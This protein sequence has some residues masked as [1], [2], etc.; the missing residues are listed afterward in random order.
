[1]DKSKAINKQSL[2]YKSMDYNALRKEGIALLEKHSGKSWT[3]FNVHDPGV[4][5]LEVLCYVITELGYKINFP[6]EDILYS[7]PDK[8]GFTLKEN[9]FFEARDIFPCQPVTIMDFRKLLIDRIEPVN[10]AWVFL[11]KDKKTGGLF[12]IWLLLDEDNN[13]REEDVIKEGHELMAEHR[14]LC[15]DVAKISIL[16]REECRLEANIF[17]ENKIDPEKTA[18]R[19]LFELEK[20]MLNPTLLR[21]SEKQMMKNGYAFENIF[22]GPEMHHGY[23]LENS[24]PD[25]PEEL[26]LLKIMNTILKIDGVYHI[27]DLAVVYKGKRYT[28]HFPLDSFL[29]IFTSKF[30]IAGG[31]ELS[32]YKND[33]LIPFQSEESVLLY[34]QLKSQ[35]KRNYS[36]DTEA[37]A[38][39]GDMVTGRFRTISD[40]LSLQNE[41]PVA[42][43][44]GK[45]GLPP[46]SD[47]KR[48]AQ[49]KQLK[50]FLLHFEQLLANS[51]VQ[52]ANLKKLFSIYPA[53]QT[54]FHQPLTDVPNLMPLIAED[55]SETALSQ[56]EAEVQHYEK[57]SNLVESETTF[58]TRRN[59]FLN[60]LLAR[61]NVTFNEA[62]YYDFGYFPEKNT[63]LRNL[64]S[65]KEYYLQHMVLLS[66]NRGKGVNYLRENPEKTALSFKRQL[67]LLL[68]IQ[69]NEDKKLSTAVKDIA[70]DLMFTIDERDDDPDN[71]I[72]YTFTKEELLE[73]FLKTGIVRENYRIET[74][75]VKS[76]DYRILLDLQKSN[77]TVETGIAETMENAIEDVEQ[78]C[79]QVLQRSIDTE[80]FYVIEHLLLRPRKEDDAEEND[81][82]EDE[83]F[84]NHRMSLIFPSWPA[85]F[86]EQGFR[87]QVESLIS[88]I[89][90]A[91]IRVDCFWMSLE[92]IIDFENTYDSWAAALKED[93]D[94][95]EAVQFA[96]AIRTFLENYNTDPV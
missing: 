63:V 45:W 25:F 39:T 92:T 50:G 58:L 84:Y 20:V 35:Q 48:K 94:S 17:I 40:Y 26:D 66:R 75:S 9:A 18:A 52:L 91:H 53:Q 14:N 90:P 11:N 12:E 72:E 22:E 46:H 1:M 13:M 3:D 47:D 78:S 23:F 5:I 37:D 83:L 55:P 24:L 82:E 74:L 6:L 65:A 96:S 89:I 10:N 76:D 70:F 33:T 2:P 36:I 59:D 4:T 79:E 51:S 29:P 62:I 88:E 16:P 85:R 69:D 7:S 42:Y 38:A 8:T 44:I 49:A 30:D 87:E 21:Y 57:W 61:F 64:I 93:K 86:Q 81:N 15:E 67:E 56:K 68:D 32:F 41:F 34:E 27:S 80:G 19:I 95:E 54:Y 73:D 60:H 77:I 28:D 71:D 43:G 31:H